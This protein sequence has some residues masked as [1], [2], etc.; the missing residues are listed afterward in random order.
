MNVENVCLLAV[1]PRRDRLEERADRAQKM[2]VKQSKI[3]FGDMINSIRFSGSRFNGWKNM[4][5]EHF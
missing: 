5:I 2:P 1:L 4:K 3:T